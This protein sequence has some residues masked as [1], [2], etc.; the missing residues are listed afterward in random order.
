MNE[1]TN[2]KVLKALGC[3]IEDIDLRNIN[4]RSK[5]CKLF[6]CDFVTVTVRNNEVYLKLEC[7]DKVTYKTYYV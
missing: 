3:K 7:G 6:N 5:L 4:I 2:K 1:I